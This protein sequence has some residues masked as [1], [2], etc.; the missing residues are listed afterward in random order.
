MKTTF[1]I[2]AGLPSGFGAG[3]RLR[4]SRRGLPWPRPNSRLAGL[5]GAGAGAAVDA[6]AGV[7]AAAAAGVGLGV[8][9]G[10]GAGADA[11][12]DAGAGVGAAAAGVAG[13][14]AAEVVSV[15]MGGLECK[16]A[17]AG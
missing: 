14:G 2:I 5:E 9:V 13:S 7:G 12:V 3:L 15:L 1:S 8:G 6:G 11:V 16:A 10:V 17:L 4:S